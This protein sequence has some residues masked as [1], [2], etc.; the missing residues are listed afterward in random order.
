[1]G[2]LSNSQPA[3][4]YVT[5]PARRGDRRMILMM[6][7]TKWSNAPDVLISEQWLPTDKG[8]MI[9]ALGIP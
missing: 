1:V 3:G 4:A 6:R 2:V 7:A 9:S 8:P 5:F